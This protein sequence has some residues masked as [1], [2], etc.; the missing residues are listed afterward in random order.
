[1]C[2]QPQAAAPHQPAPAPILQQ[3]V[4]AVP[5]QHLQQGLDH[6]YSYCEVRFS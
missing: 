2:V 3:P 4:Q 5:Q 6:L 1:M